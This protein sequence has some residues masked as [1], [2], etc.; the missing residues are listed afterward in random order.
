MC[1]VIEVI[2][3]NEEGENMN[4]NN[5]LNR[6]IANLYDSFDY[7]FECW[8]RENNRWVEVQTWEYWEAIV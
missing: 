5:H 1:T 6:V 8:I 7:K 4:K 3:T 2:T